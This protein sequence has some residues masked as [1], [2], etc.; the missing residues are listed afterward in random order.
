MKPK[1]ETGRGTRVVNGFRQRGHGEVSRIEGFSDAVFGFSVTLLVVSLEVP[2][3]FDERLHVLAGFPSFARTFAMLAQI[4]YIQNRFFRRYG[5]VDGPTIVLNLVLLFT[6]VYFTY[7]LKFLFGP[8]RVDGA[9]RDD[10][11][12]AMYAVYSLGY[13][14]V[15]AIFGLLHVHALRVA[16][17][18]DLTPLEIYDTR[19][20]VAQSS[21]QI[22]VAATSFGLAAYA[23]GHISYHA[24]ALMGGFAYFLIPVG[25]WLFGVTGAPQ[26]RALRA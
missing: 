2:R 15:F 18:L 26:R 17:D 1:P 7:P 25:L 14:A 20:S 22:G 19:M 21:F 12:V 6:V 24:A 23:A 13:G 10:Q 8:S 16:R 11:I 5:L 9:V 4:W 3:T